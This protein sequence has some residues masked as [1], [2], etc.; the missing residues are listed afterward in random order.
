MKKGEKKNFRNGRWDSNILIYSKLLRCA[1]TLKSMSFS[2]S[3]L[4]WLNTG[5][6]LTT[7]KL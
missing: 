7:N 6:I 2:E 4:S 5:L 1:L 3:N